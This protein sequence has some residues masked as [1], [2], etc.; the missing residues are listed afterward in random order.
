MTKQNEPIRQ[1]DQ[2]GW[3]DQGPRN[4]QRDSE[5]LI[6]WC[7]QRLITEQLQI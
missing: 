3:V 1:A 6:F 5:I 4:V 2:T 7:H